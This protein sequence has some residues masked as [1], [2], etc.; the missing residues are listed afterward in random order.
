MNDQRNLFVAIAISVAI[1]IGWQYF[2]PAPVSRWP[3]NRPTARPPGPNR[4]PGQCGEP[5][6]CPAIRRRRRR[7]V[8]RATTPWAERIA[9]LTPAMHGSIALTGARIDDITLAKYRETPAADAREIDLMSPAE[10]PQP[11]WAEFGWVATDTNVKVPGPD[12]VWQAQGN[13]R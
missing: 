7:P 6:R 13:G 11:Y 2:F 8:R 12:S 5:G 10:S 3:S 4:R 9:I 1:L